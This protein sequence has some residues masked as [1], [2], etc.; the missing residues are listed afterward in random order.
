MGIRAGGTAYY[1][2]AMNVPTNCNKGV[3]LVYV[4]NRVE[5]ADGTPWKKTATCG[6]GGT[7]TATLK[8]GEPWAVV[9]GYSCN[10]KANFV[11]GQG[12]SQISLTDY[13]RNG[14][15]NAN[16]KYG[17]PNSKDRAIQ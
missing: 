5:C 14:V 15:C 16:P 13:C 2:D 8:G 11:N 3:A 10:E 1:I 4:A 12:Y 9:D 7:L 6:F 17:G